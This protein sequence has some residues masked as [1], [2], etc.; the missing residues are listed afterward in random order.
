MSLL[1]RSFILGLTVAAT[2]V[3][4]PASASAA[5]DCDKVAEPGAG[6]AQRLVDSVTPGQVGCLRGGRYTE[7]VT[8]RK[9]GSGNSARVTIRSFPGERAE[10]YGRL[11]VNDSANF[12]TVEDLK[13][14]GAGAPPCPSGGSCTILPSPT[15]NG[16]DVIFQNNEVTNDHTAICFSLG[17]TGWGIAKRVIIQQ[18]RIHD[19][20]RMSPITNHDHGIYLSA[21]EDVQILGNAIYDN[22]DRGIQLYPAADRTVVRGNVIDGNGQGVIFSGD[23]GETS[24]DNIVE[25]NVISNSRIRYNVESWYPTSVGTGNVAR[26]NCLY[27][28]KQGNVGTQE[29]FVATNN[30]VT[31]PL[32]TDRAAKDF[33]LKAESKCAAI[34]A[35]AAAP[36]VPLDPPPTT[37]APA[38]TTGT[39]DPATGEPTTTEGKPGK[40]VLENVSVKKSR[41]TG[42][43]RIRIAGRVAGNAARVRVQARRGSGWKT[44]ATVPDVGGTFRI[45]LRTRV[46][47]ISSA[48]RMTVR[49]VVPGISASNIVRARTR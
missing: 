33:S 34:L 20:G 28:G 15:V 17:S 35:G 8:I 5:A 49:V 2:A 41:R 12:V 26:N 9:G 37:T 4:S 25:N 30:L 47:G 14:N 27:N 42:Y 46:K 29:G 19:C 44:I 40:V 24:D 45:A 32:Y 21:S 16:D 36:S 3:A 7:N 10:L 38:P 31:D 48:G 39:T 13:L 18:N 11:A 22:S 43:A 1:R 23:G 6:A